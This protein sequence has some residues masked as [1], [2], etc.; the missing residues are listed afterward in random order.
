MRALIATPSRV[1]GVKR[2]FFAASKAAVSNSVPAERVTAASVTAPLSS[3][4][5]VSSTVAFSFLDAGKSGVARSTS[6]GG[7]TFGCASAGWADSSSQ[8]ARA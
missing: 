3:T 2:S 7:V 8:Q 4:V 1:A 6:S 5:S